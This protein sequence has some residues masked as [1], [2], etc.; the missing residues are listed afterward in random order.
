L[1]SI[2]Y[3]ILL[4]I[5]FIKFIITRDLDYWLKGPSIEKSNVKW[6]NQKK[7]SERIRKQNQNQKLSYL[8]FFKKNQGHYFVFFFSVMH[9]KIFFSIKKTF[10][11]FYLKLK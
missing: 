1:I 5:F 8:F 11:Y 7:K 2:V 6:W 4:Y 10:Y 3:C 9:V